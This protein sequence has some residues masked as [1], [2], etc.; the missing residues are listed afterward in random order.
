MEPEIDRDALQG[1]NPL[2]NI[3]WTQLTVE[4]GAQFLT[5]YMVTITTIQLPQNTRSKRQ[6]PS[7]S[8]TMNYSVDKTGSSFELPAKPYTAY[9]SQVF[10][11]LDNDGIISTSPVTSPATVESPEAAPGSP[12]WNISITASSF[13]SVSLAWMIPE[14]PNGIVT[15]YTVSERLMV[16]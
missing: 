5:Q 7:E 4:D 16:Q 6:S 15:V 13:T 11:V 1:V 8:T 12:P 3:S 10:A 14:S 2:L 9:T